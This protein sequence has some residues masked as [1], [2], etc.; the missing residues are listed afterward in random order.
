MTRHSIVIIP[1]ARQSIRWL[2]TVVWAAILASGL[3]CREKATPTPSVTMAASFDGTRALNNVRSFVALGPREGGTE[4]SRGAAEY[5][6]HQVQGLGVAVELQRFQDA[7]PG[8]TAEFHNVLARIPGHGK[9]LIL[10][11]AHFDTKSG[12]PGFVGANDSGSGVGVLLELARILR[13]E[14]HHGPEIWLVFFDGEECRVSYGP[15]DGFHGSR[16][17]AQQ[18]VATGRSQ[19]VRAMILLDMIG[20]RDLTVTLPSNGTPA[21]TALVLTAAEQVGVREKFS[22]APGPIFD[23]HQPFL[24]AGIPAVD[25][26]DFRYGSAPG[27]NDY[28]HTPADTMDKLGAESLQT[29]GRVVLQMLPAL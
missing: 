22:L 16:H 14:W 13:T 5:L 1:I 12:I 7:A 23:D 20:D 26:I 8:G 28:W 19:D 4:N 15:H 24:E 29:I 17:L 25:L 3:G 10:L 27:L 6:V 21:L 2:T 18:L 9:G 11:G